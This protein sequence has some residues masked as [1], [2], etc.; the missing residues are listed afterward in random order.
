MTSSIISGRVNVTVG[1]QMFSIPAE[2]IPQV[3]NLLMTLQSIQVAENPSPALQY[4]GK[5]LF[6]G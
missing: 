4:Q 3:L 6:N 5:T 2:K 1:H